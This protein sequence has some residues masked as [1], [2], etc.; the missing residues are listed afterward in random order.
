MIACVGVGREVTKIHA[1]LFD[2]MQRRVAISKAGQIK[3]GA[4]VERPS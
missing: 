3:K 1:K 2:E 4:S